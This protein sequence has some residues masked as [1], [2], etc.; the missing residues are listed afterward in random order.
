[1]RSRLVT[2]TFSRPTFTMRSP[3]GFLRL[4]NSSG[5]T[6]VPRFWRVR[7]TLG[8]SVGSA[9]LG[10]A[11][12]RV[13]IRVGQHPAPGRFDDHAQILKLRLAA[14]LALYLIGACDQ[15]RRIARA[16][17]SYADRNFFAGYLPSSVDHFANA[18]AVTAT[19][20]I[21]DP[22]AVAHRAE[23][24][25]M[26]SSEIDD[27]DIVAQ[28]SSVGR[29]VVIAVDLDQGTFSCRG[30]KGDGNGVRFG[31]VIFTALLARARGIKVTQRD[32]AQSVCAFVPVHRSLER[33]FCFA[34]GIGRVVGRRFLDRL[35]YRLSV[36]CRG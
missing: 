6:V 3:F 10:M 1:M 29:W 23:S 31:I 12:V 36:S 33:E 7:F 28:A 34:V 20:K 16:T 24:E 5:V 22:A 27:V 9:A 17:W 13:S 35:G 32:I 19:A 18:V 4:K 30:L 25:D 11:L 15:D 26:R 21:V 2:E 14:K 8:F